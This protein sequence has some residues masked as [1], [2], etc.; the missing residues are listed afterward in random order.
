[1]KIE[2]SITIQCPPED[3][4]EFLAVRSND[5]LWMASVVESDWLD[6][7]TD[8]AAPIGVG[9]RGRMV[10][11]FPGRR[12][13]FIDEV[14]EYEPGRRIEHRTV[15]GPIPLRTACICAPAGDACRTTVVAEADRLPG[16]VFGRLAAP[17]V[18]SVIRRG[19]KVDL[20]RLKNIFEAE[21]R[22]TSD[23]SAD[24]GDASQRLPDRPR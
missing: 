1:M 15:E 13:V 3:V 4:F 19:F 20:A 17:V 9:R 2:E 11:K 10:M 14:T 21:A 23:E 6:P 24:S 8:P 7:T 18:T 22:P 16:G 5:A 12:A